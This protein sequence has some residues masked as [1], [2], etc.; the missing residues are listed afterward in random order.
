MDATRLC[1][2]VPNGLPKESISLGMGPESHSPQQQPS[3][4]TE[5]EIH[6]PSEPNAVEER[7]NIISGRVDSA[8]AIPLVRK[9]HYHPV[10]SAYLTR[11]EAKCHPDA[12]AV[13]SEVDA[14]F[15]EHWP[16]PSE[17]ARKA[18]LETECARWICWV[19]PYAKK[20]RIVVV[21]KVGVLFFLL[22]GVLPDVW[23]ALS[24]H[25]SKAMFKRFLPIV[26]GRVQPVRTNPYEWILY[27]L[28]AMMRAINED[29]AESVSREMAVWANAQVDQG[30]NNFRGMGAFL[31]LRCRDSGSGCVY[32][33]L[34]WLRAHE[35]DKAINTKCPN[36]FV[37]AMMAYALDLHI[38]PMEQASIIEIEKLYAYHAS[39]VNDIESYDKEVRASGQNGLQNMVQIQAD[40]TGCSTAA[41]KRIL[42]VLC[43]EWEL[44]YLE[45]VAKREASAEGCSET[46]KSYMKGLE[47]VMGGNEIWNGYTRRYHQAG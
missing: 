33:L 2:V 43:R 27:D 41:A 10:D 30:R 25:E 21:T 17:S 46:L 31:Q 32:M 13:C 16:W 5:T 7:P 15:T 12:D 8:Q 3:F 39:V 9:G 26:E 40:E 28:R 4:N 20:D 38:S 36:R 29:L 45:L 42:W 22:D 34:I 1:D 35:K 6:H 14:F 18:F 47:Y 19:Y 44:Q 23:E 24:P 11:F 37:A